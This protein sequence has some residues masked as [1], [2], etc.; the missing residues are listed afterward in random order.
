[1][2]FGFL[3][4]FPHPAERLPTGLELG[5]RLWVAEQVGQRALRPTQHALRKYRLRYAVPLKLGADPLRQFFG[6]DLLHVGAVAVTVT[7]T[8]AVAIAVGGHR[9]ILHQH[10]GGLD[11]RGGLLLV[12]HVHPLRVVR[13]RRRRRGHHHFLRLDDRV[14][15]QRRRVSWRHDHPAAASRRTRMRRNRGQAIDVGQRGGAAERGHRWRMQRARVLTEI[16][17]VHGGR[18]GTISAAA[19]NLRVRRVVATVRR[20]HALWRRVNASAA[21]LTV[22]CALR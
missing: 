10:R 1:M 8:V 13:R 2:E 21:V 12:H 19:A 14:Y 20:R 17:T 3:E 6:V 4:P 11:Q 9:G 15:D 18:S 7:V 5:P 22:R 16:G